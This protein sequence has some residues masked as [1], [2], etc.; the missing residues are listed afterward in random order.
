M[1]SS[2][3]LQKGMTVQGMPAEPITVERMTAT[4]LPDNSVRSEPEIRIVRS[5]GEQISQIEMVNYS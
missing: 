1:Y 4:K 3:D 5:I 2:I